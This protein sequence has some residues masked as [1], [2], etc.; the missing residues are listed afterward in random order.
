M[1]VRQPS[2]PWFLLLLRHHAEEEIRNCQSETYKPTQG[3]SKESKRKIDQGV[4]GGKGKK[5]YNRARLLCVGVLGEFCND[6]PGVP[7]VF[8]KNACKLFISRNTIDTHTHTHVYNT[9]NILNNLLFFYS[10][11]FIFFFS[12]LNFLKIILFQV[13]VRKKNNEIVQYFFLYKKFV[14]NDGTIALVA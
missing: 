12:C 13:A 2:P 7:R 10:H 14:F 4:K 11:L 1:E 8:D 5:N 6:Q 3:E 9:I